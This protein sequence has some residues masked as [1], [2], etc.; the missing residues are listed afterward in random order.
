MLPPPDLSA[1]PERDVV[2][3]ARR[4]SEDAY[5]ELVRRYQARLR[6]HI[7]RFV[8]HTERTKDLAQD[9]FVRAFA[10]LDRF[11]SERKFAPWL[12]T[13][14]RNAAHDYIHR[15]PPDSPNSP[16]ALPPTSIDPERIAAPTPDDDGAP[17]PAHAAAPKGDPTG[18]ATAPPHRPRVRG[19][20]GAG[21]AARPRGCNP[22][23]AIRQTTLTETT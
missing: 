4:R 11:R 23:A 21:S 14:G 13:I 2:R 17:R 20:S 19:G 5:R 22:P 15:R 18:R 3:L 12:F 1:A 10:A 6:R 16:R 8:H 7:Y 9:T